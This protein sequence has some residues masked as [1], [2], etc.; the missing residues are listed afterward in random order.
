MMMKP[1]A[2]RG[3]WAEGLNVKDLTKE[4]ARLSFMLVA[5]I[6]MMRDCKI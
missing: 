5:V 3:K 6:A 1:K 4:K 2:G